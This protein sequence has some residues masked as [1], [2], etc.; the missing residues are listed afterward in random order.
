[1][2]RLDGLS[3]LRL[4]MAR[5]PTPVLVVSSQARRT[6]V[7]KAL[8][9]GAL[10][11]VAKPD[12]RHGGL[13]ALRDELL[14]KLEVVGALRPGSVGAV[15]EAPARRRA[16]SAEAEPPRIVVVGAST[17]GP[18]AL[19]QLLGGLPGDL[20]LGILVA[21]HMPP[22]FT[23]TFAE[24]LSRHTAFSAREASDGDAV[25]HGRVLVAPGGRHLALRRDGAGALRAAIEPAGS[26]PWPWCP[27]VD[28]LFAT[29]AAALGSRVCAVVLTGM[30]QD[31]REGAAAVKRAGGLT[32]AESEDSAVV[33]GMPKSAAES[34]VVDE[35][36]PLDGIA[37]RIMRF[38]RGA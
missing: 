16:S 30:G 31:G 28:R 18:R 35:V 15:P 32:L 7:F 24:R 20:P 22:G 6:D 8:E 38:A 9:L 26:G 13:D 21:Q 12:A 25:A 1:M 29:A 11:F 5:R 34:G 14:A 33:F 37:D 27:S 10:D 2:P 3:F 19:L 23:T 4:L 17:G 36:L